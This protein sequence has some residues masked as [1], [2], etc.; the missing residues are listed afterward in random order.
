MPSMREQVLRQCFDRYDGQFASED[1]ANNKLD[2]E[3]IKDNPPLRS[4][5]GRRLGK[6]VM[7]HNPEFVVAVPY[8][9]DWEAADV[10]EQKD[11]PVVRLKRNS[12]DK[13]R[14]EFKSLGD[15]ALCMT[16][17]IGVLLED[18]FSKFTNT[19]RCLAIPELG[20]RI[21]A[22][23]AVWDRGFPEEREELEIPHDALITEPIPRM[24][25]EDSLYWKYA[26]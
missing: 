26:A 9:A 1:Y 14:F 10:G 24:L 21:V 15:K 6:R 18:V 12:L 17:D 19:R 4:M 25:P 2:G 20:N 23:E 8:G 16:L 3:L 7:K 22:V 5:V 11:L 13:N